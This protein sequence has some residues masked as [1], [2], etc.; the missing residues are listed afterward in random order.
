MRYTD[1]KIDKLI[2]TFR[3]LQIRVNV[4]SKSKL[5]CFLVESKESLIIG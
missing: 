1:L 2:S 5:E 3:I 4:V